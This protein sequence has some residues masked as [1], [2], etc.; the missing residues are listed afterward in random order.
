MNHYQLRI[1]ADDKQVVLERILQ[2]TRYRGFLIE[3]IKARVNT[4]TNIGT[5]ELM[6]RSERPISLLVD[7]INKLID[8]KDVKVDKNTTK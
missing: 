7:Q 1:K 6:V 5:I 4:G 8:I 2:V 3:G